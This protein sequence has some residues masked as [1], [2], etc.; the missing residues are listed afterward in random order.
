[1]PDAQKVPPEGVVSAKALL[2]RR[3]LPIVG[4]LLV[5][6]TTARQELGDDAYERL[7][8]N[9]RSLSIDELV[10]MFQSA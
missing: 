10:E 4:G 5:V 2:W 6:V 3:L 9:G 7:E 1:M 8:A